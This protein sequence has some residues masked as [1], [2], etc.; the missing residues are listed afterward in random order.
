LEH[1]TGNVTPS[2]HPADPHKKQKGLVQAESQL[3]EDGA[4]LGEQEIQTL[5]AIQAFLIETLSPDT[6]GFL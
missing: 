3:P 6:V 5:F 4:C 2:V 1:L